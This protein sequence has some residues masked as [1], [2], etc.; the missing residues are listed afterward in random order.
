MTRD[1]LV[2][3]FGDDMGKR[4]AL[5]WAPKD[6]ENED[7]MFK[8]ALV[9]TIWDKTARKVHVVSKGLPEQQIGR[10]HV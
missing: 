5:D 10:A 8:R 7:E 1:E 6:K 3:Q 2:K 4:C 9:W